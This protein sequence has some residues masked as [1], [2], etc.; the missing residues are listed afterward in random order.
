MLARLVGATIAAGDEASRPD[1]HAAVCSPTQGC[2]QANCD[3]PLSDIGTRSGGDGVWPSTIHH[4][5]SDA[6]AACTVTYTLA[7]KGVSASAAL[8]ASID[9]PAASAAYPVPGLGSRLMASG[10]QLRCPKP[11]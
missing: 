1:V 10:E 3:R 11:G 4:C 8:T 6:N 5:D 2:A 7:I 9:T